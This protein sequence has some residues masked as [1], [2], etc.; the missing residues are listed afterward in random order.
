MPKIESEAPPNVEVL[1][2]KHPETG[3]TVEIISPNGSVILNT[4]GTVQFNGGIDPDEASRIFWEALA[5]QFNQSYTLTE[6]FVE[7]QTEL[8][9]HI[10]MMQKRIDGSAMPGS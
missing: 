3:S 5:G 1:R 8:R 4:D 9:N 10:N 7:M 2:I 6:K